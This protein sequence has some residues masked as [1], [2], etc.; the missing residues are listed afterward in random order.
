MSIIRCALRST[1]CQDLDHASKWAAMSFFET[2][3]RRVKHHMEILEDIEHAE[4]VDA[5]AAKEAAVVK[6]TAVQ[7]RIRH[8]FGVLQ[9]QNAVRS[10][11]AGQ[12]ARAP[13]VSARAYSCCHTL[14]P[15]TAPA[16]LGCA[17]R[18]AYPESAPSD[19]CG[20][21]GV[22]S[23]AQAWR[24]PKEAWGEQPKADYG[25]SVEHQRHFGHHPPTEAKLPGRQIRPH[26][27]RPF[28]IRTRMEQE[29]QSGF[30][31]VLRRSA[32]ALPL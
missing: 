31:K 19:C 25:C 5:I 29:V 15:S 6:R 2:D 23:G 26:T 10:V 32:Y 3:P 14:K 17:D 16:E 8:A 1:R 7:D 20:P 27:A 12:K 24:Q 30:K 4:R 22:Y 28:R 13:S 18:T 21:E 9:L 11:K